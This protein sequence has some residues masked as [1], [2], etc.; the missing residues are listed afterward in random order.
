MWIICQSGIRFE[1]SKTEHA[2]NN[3][4]FI[5]KLAYQQFIIY[6]YLLC[7]EQNNKTYLFPSLLLTWI[8]IILLCCPYTKVKWCRLKPYSWNHY[9]IRICSFKCRTFG[10]LN[11]DAWSM[12]FDILGFYAKTFRTDRICLIWYPS[13]DQICSFLRFPISARVIIQI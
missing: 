6:I 1:A 9:S 11:L 5:F 7:M 10:K 4:L 13:T 2:N 8:N 3:N 12:L